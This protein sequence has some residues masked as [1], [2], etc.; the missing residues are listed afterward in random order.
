MISFLI[1][2][3][4]TVLFG[5]LSVVLAGGSFAQIPPWQGFS[6]DIE[7][8]VPATPNNNCET[9]FLTSPPLVPLEGAPLLVLFHSY[10][11]HH[12]E[13]TTPSTGPRNWDYYDLI[14]KAK[15][16][17]WIVM[18]HD[19]GQLDA[20][21]HTPVPCPHPTPEPTG[22]HF[23]TYATEPFHRHSEAA[24]RDAIQR[25]PINKDRVYGYGF[26][27][28]GQEALNYAARHLDPLSDEGMFAAVISSSGYLSPV[29]EE[30]CSNFPTDCVYTNAGYCAPATTAK[31]RFWWQRAGVMT[32]YCGASCV[33]SNA[34]QDVSY[35]D[36]QIHNIAALPIRLFYEQGEASNTRMAGSNQYLASWLGT[37]VLQ[38]HDC[39]APGCSSGQPDCN[40]STSGLPN[41]HQWDTVCADDALNFLQP[42]TLSAHLANVRSAGLVLCAENDRRYLHFRVQRAN[43]NDF[44]R[45]QWSTQPL[46]NQITLE[47]PSA[48]GHGPFV[49]NVA[50]VIVVGDDPSLG[51]VDPLSA[52]DTGS[53][54]RVRTTYS[55]NFLGVSGYDS[56]SAPTVA[57]DNGTTQV[58]IGSSFSN[59]TVVFR[60]LGVGTYIIYP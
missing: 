17:G 25:F 52:L 53:I 38:V 51:T 5:L 2:V 29:Y 1:A 50:R 33:A 60:A 41:H 49:P 40:D 13:H 46:V 34:F 4:A 54:V 19:G 59:G 28:G 42:N 57:Y 56:G 23:T 11:S 48:P 37:G 16:R 26:S 45:V 35:W 22:G 43:S 12:N 3:R 21:C 39:A 10:Y 18:M 14:T 30:V 24:I 6:G 27:M 15:E 47:S 9:Y 36:S 7:I 55:L 44:G 32:L 8:S 31:E 58:F 20:A